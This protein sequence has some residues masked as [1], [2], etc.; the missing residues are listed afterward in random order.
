MVTY[1]YAPAGD[2]GAARQ[3]QLLAEQLASRGRRV[4]VVTARF[5]GHRR[6][7]QL[8][9][10][11]VHRVWTI[12]RPGRFS[13]TFIPSLARFLLLEGRRYDMWHAHQAFYNAAAALALAR[14]S[15]RPR[16]IVKV[17]ASGPYGDLARLRSAAMGDWVRKALLDADALISLNR[18]MTDEL[19]A[20]GMDAS[21]IRSIPNG[22]D[23]GSFS[24]PSSQRRLE[25]RSKLGIPVGARVA[26]FA[27]RLT[28]DK[29][30]DFLIDAWRSVER[31][32]PGETWTL[33]V[34][35]D[36]VGP[37][38]YAERGN[39]ELRTARFV[40]KVPDVRPLL[41]AADVLVHPSLSEGLSNIV[42]EAMA[43]G[44]PVI[45]TRTGGLEEQVVDGATGILVPPRDADV[46]AE[47]LVAL[48]RDEGRRARMGSAGRIRAESRYSL[49]S[50]VDAYED[51]YDQLS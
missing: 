34:A 49:P 23:C 38:L 13:M 11:D 44:L 43:V 9:G 39:R 40:G 35:G 20:A 31:Q 3:A 7:E 32:C 48:L 27:G 10:V 8:A 12:P 1:Q 41:Y 28:E 22:V 15:G 50:V 47:A 18:Q 29:G 4:G 45:G 30:I 46:L 19:V 2:G 24:P 17:A 14:L 51:L 25:A 21:R 36:G 26:V 16:C 33:L 5:P 42:L 37:A 6:S